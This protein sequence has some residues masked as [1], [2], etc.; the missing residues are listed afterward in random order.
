MS[1]TFQLMYKVLEPMNLGTPIESVDG[2]GQ[3]LK[4]DVEARAK[5]LINRIFGPKPG[6]EEIIVRSLPVPVIMM[7]SK[8]L[9][10]PLPQ[11]I[12]ALGA[13]DVVTVKRKP[14]G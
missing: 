9:K 4:K 3:E 7:I 5:K 2:K 11:P 10:A 12:M 8:L 13:N 1:N 6:E 14:R